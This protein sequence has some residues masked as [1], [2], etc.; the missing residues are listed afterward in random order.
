MSVVE[1]VWWLGKC[2]WVSRVGGV[3]GFEMNALHALN[4]QSGSTIGAAQTRRRKI[5]RD[6]GDVGLILTFCSWV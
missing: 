3:F 5:K 2:G 6:S 4:W 1:A